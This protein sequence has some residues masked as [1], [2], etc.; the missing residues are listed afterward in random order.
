MWADLVKSNKMLPHPA[1]GA[2]VNVYYSHY[3]TKILYFMQLFF[4]GGFS[5]AWPR[6]DCSE[7]QSSLSLSLKYLQTKYLQRIKVEKTDG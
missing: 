5:A 3:G 6:A 7:I 4:L 2:T 1:I